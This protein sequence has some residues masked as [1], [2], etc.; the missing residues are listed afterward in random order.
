M[1]TSNILE[2]GARKP[3]LDPIIY[4]A[5]IANYEVLANCNTPYGV[6]SKV[7]V[8]FDV[9][10]PTETGFEAVTIRQSY[11]VSNHPGSMFDK[12]VFGV[13]GQ[14]VGKRFD[15]DSL[16]GAEVMI[17]IKHNVTADGNTFDNVDSVWRES[18]DLTQGQI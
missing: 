2:F 3:K 9:E 1:T 12:L 15:L 17:Q 7:L 5:K 16:L 6:R 8:S 14:P 11:L 18:M 13:T 4:R 10:R